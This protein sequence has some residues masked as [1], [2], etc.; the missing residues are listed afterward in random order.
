LKRPVQ[1][2]NP[3]IELYFRKVNAIP[4]MSNPDKEL[5]KKAV[6]DQFA[7]RNEAIIIEEEEEV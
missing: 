1:R 4:G 5:L 7:R 3:N 2:V 6:L